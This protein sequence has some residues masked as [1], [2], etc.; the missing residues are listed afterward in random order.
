MISTSRSRWRGR[1]APNARTAAFFAF[2]SAIVGIV[3][4][5]LL[6]A[7]YAVQAGRPERGD[8]LGQANDLTGSLFSALIIPVALALGAYPPQP[9]MRRVTLALGIPALVLLTVVGPLLVFGVLSFTVQTPIAV[10]AFEG[11]AAWLFL[12]SR[13]QRK[14]GALTARVAR[15]GEYVGSGVLAVTG[16]AA[17][18]LLLPWQSTPQLI[19]FGVGA[20]F[21]FIC[22][23]VGFPIWQLLVGR[24]FARAARLRSAPPPARGAAYRGRKRR[25]AG[26]PPPP[27]RSKPPQRP[28]SSSTSRST[29]PKCSSVDRL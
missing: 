14:A 9:R 8:W 7:F 15:V 10:T 12:V 27:L 16:V 19:V 26:W 29:A 2:A 20:A 22:S 5:L 21:A 13:W 24:H 1:I 25:A 4:G 3:S 6:I 23:L 18:G 11:I 17:L 28:S